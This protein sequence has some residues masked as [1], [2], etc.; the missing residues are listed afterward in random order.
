[1]TED[2]FYS[3]KERF[4]AYAAPFIDGA[5]DPEPYK[6][7]QV[8][9]SRVCDNISMLA[10]SLD[11]NLTE[12]NIARAAALFHDVGRF[13]QFE[14]YGTFSDPLSKNHAALSVG[15]MVKHNF[16]EGIPDQE[17]QLIL[18]AVA[19]HNRPRLPEGL[20]PRLS[21]LARLLRDADKIDI[22]KVMLDLYRSTEN[23]KPSFITHDQRDDGR[24]SGSLVDDIMNGKGVHY[25]RVATLNDMKLFQVSMIYDLNFP[26][27]FAA[28]RDRQVVQ[29]I[30]NSMPASPELESLAGVMAVYIDKRINNTVA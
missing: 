12:A 15:V 7:K 18:R 3:L 19:L 1:M 30:L 26:A 13:P 24:I 14:I 28:M 4:H 6:L 20:E 23:G 5:P 27:A 29:V 2:D 10:R 16:L 25:N 8:H 21:L 9:T 11:L 17:R 22:Y